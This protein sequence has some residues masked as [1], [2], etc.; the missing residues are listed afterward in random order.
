MEFYGE[1][2]KEIIEEALLS[3]KESTIDKYMRE[4]SQLKATLSE[5][6]A[7]H[8]KHKA[9]VEPL[10]QKESDRAKNASQEVS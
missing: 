4:I 5:M 3:E 2:V 8:T 10:L 9:V 1:R 6:Y 7:E